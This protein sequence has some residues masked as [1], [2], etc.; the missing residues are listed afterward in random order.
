MASPGTVRLLTALWEGSLDEVRPTLDVDT[1]EVTYPD[2]TQQLDDRDGETFDVLETLA[3]RDLL[4]RE[5]QEKQYICPRCEA[6]GMQYT[7]AC[8][9]CESPQTIRTERYVHSDCGYDG[10]R[11]Q[12]VGEDGVTCPECETTVESLSQLESEAVHICEDCETAFER[13]A[14]RLRCRECFLVSQPLQTIERILYRYYISEEG[15]NWVEKQLTARQLLV[16]I[17]ETRT[18]ETEI[19]TTV[20]NRSGETVPVHVFA[21][22]DLLDDRVIGAIHERPDEADVRELQS[23]AADANARATLVTTS[24]E[25]VGN[26]VSEMV[27]EEGVS[28]LRLTRNDT[29]RR[30]YEIV[31]GTEARNSFVGRIA[32]IFKPQH[33]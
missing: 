25:I 19:D 27:A 24:G 14:H 11:E 21:H 7:T 15:A 8:P 2:A 1:G 16:E 6:K 29:L 20:E 18:L 13:P 31:E 12:F 17:L 9:T 28:V 22:D 32:N 4:Y 23:V 33:G 10:L 3:E 5:F 30:E 26:E